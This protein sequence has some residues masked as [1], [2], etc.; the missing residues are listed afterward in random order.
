MEIHHQK[1]HA[2]YVKNYNAALE[3]LAEATAKNDIPALI[4]IQGAIRFN[5]GG[6]V[7]HS[8][9]WTNLAPPKSGGGAP[10]SGTLATALNEQYGNLDRFIEKFNTAAAGVQGSGWGW[11]VFNKDVK[12]LQ[13]A[14]T[15]NQDPA[16][17]LGNVVPLLGID[18]W[19]HAYYLD[20]KSARPDYLKAIWKV[21]NWSTVAER[22]EAA[23]KEQ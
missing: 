15:P 18:V 9:F 21:V 19:E 20:Y 14:T 10:P 16:I 1:H 8:I 17:T 12:R 22:L 11:L 13:I 6:H 2:A 5:G 7:N 23:K 3:Q 4:R